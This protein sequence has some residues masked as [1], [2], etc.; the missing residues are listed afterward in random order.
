MRPDGTPLPIFGF[1]VAVYSHTGIR[2]IFLASPEVSPQKS[3]GFESIH[4]TCKIIPPMRHP[5]PMLVNCGLS[6]VDPR[7]I[8]ANPIRTIRPDGTDARRDRLTKGA[9]PVSV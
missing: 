6:V 7:I 9:H 5:I 4:N 2:R 3:L 8:T 1:T